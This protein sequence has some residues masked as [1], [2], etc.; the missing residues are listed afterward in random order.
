M[1]DPKEGQDPEAGR[2]E[3]VPSGTSVEQPIAQ[4]EV[5]PPAPAPPDL[6]APAA[7]AQA[8]A[9]AAEEPPPAPEV[10]PEAPVRKRRPVGKTAIFVAHGM[11]QQIPWQTLDQV[12]TGLLGQQP[13]AA[14]RVRAVHS[15]APLLRR[16]ELGLTDAKGEPREVHVYEGYWA[17]FTEGQVTLRDV[18]R[19]LVYAGRNGMKNSSGE[20]SRK[21]F[22]KFPA[23]PASARN[24]V[25]LA[26]TLAVL[27]SL[28]LLNATIL[29]VAAARSPL[30][31]PPDWLGAG[32]FNDL[33]TV[34]HAVLLVALAFGLLLALTKKL[35]AVAKSGRAG[36]GPVRASNVA[37]TAAF[38]LL[39]VTLLLAAASVPLLFY[40]HVKVQEDT[41]LWNYFFSDFPIDSDRFNTA[42]SYF[43]LGALVLAFV[44]WVVKTAV[45]VVRALGSELGRQRA[46][47]EGAAEGSNAERGKGWVS[48]GLV[49]GG[50]LLLAIVGA[51]VWQFVDRFRFF[52]GGG[53]FDV[54]RL[55]IAWPLLVGASWFVRQLLIQYVGDVAVYVA[56]HRLDR[57]RELRDKIR[58]TVCETAHAIYSLR[59]ESNPRAFEYDRVLVVGHSL[60]TAVVYDTMNHLINDDLIP[61]PK[62][63]PLKVV[64]RTKLFLTFGSPLDKFAFLFAAVGHETTEAREALANVAEPMIQSYDTRP[65]KWINLYSRWDIVSGGLD[66]YDLPGK[67]DPRSVQDIPDPEAT[68]LLAAHVE[69]W[70]NDLLYRTLLAEI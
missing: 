29:L 32:L 59:Q 22:E 9:P 62:Y 45:V 60:G 1:A 50:V 58:Q 44:A 15:G 42:I 4:Q 2:Y 46:A 55:G 43:F 37:A 3:V 54:L 26:L 21:L 27:A 8:P 7:E 36:W 61:P 64:E 31:N 17:P 67:S 52:T 11:G 25:Y 68:T 49:A 5:A 18:M 66:F 19:F 12:A 10:V 35:R 16:I 63:K 48:L 56:S 39:L 51:M 57:F 34:F 30:Q 47:G 69:Y 53:Y 65:K 70:E 40:G 6:A 38:V 13:Q 20:F 28:V 33:T 14:T 23:F 41:R 24:S